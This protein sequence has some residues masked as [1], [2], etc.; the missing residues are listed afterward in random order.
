MQ[1]DHILIRYGELGLKGKNIRTF[2]VKLQQNIQQ[3][4][5][6]YPD[7]KVKRTQGRLFVILNGQDPKPI[8]DICKNIF[9]IHS[10]SLAVKVENNETEIRETV[11]KIM[12]RET[13]N[14]T[15]KVKAKRANKNFPVRSLELNRSIGGD[16]LKNLPHLKVDVHHPDIEVVID[17]RAEGT[18]ILTEIIYGPG[19]LPVGTAG[20]SLLMLSGGID[21]PVAGY[22]MMKR[23]VQ[24]EM[25][26]FHSPPFTSER[27]KQKV[28]DLTKKLT[29]YSYHI[30]VHLV[31]FT[32]V[33]Q[34]IFKHYPERYGMTIMRRVMM[35]ISEAICQ[36]ENI[37]SITT[38]E[39]LGQVAS[40]TM[41]SM[42][43]INE[44]TNLP[45]L[46]PL[47]AMDKEE[48]VDISK[49]IDT[50]EI[51]IQPYED[52]CTVFVPKSPVIKPQRK[53]VLSF[54]KAYDLTDAINTAVEETKIIKIS[55]KDDEKL[56]DLL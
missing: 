46:R 49:Q 25:V 38:G 2:L 43:V 8:I 30:K 15:F 7:I 34:L 40:Q 16:I 24:L 41:E 12:S 4:L 56:D 1:Y 51:S 21:S 26:H 53:R 27:A 35:K 45:V 23:G 13:E 32:E 22:V 20:K 36:Q 37:L 52:C 54:E 5:I 29:K 33:Q 39:S 6:K 10:L 55:N 50:Y 18:Y 28:L 47:I 42:N 19:G 14:K 48:I 9:G 44:V 3:S 31:P 11:L 17:I